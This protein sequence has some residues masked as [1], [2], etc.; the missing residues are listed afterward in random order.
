[1]ALVGNNKGSAFILGIFM[2]LGLA[3]LGDQI[4]TGFIRFKEFE[5]VVSVKGLSE[6]EVNADIVIWPITFTAASNDL[7]ELY[8]QLSANN[9]RIQQ[10][11]IGK[12]L[13][14]SEISRLAPA[15][16]DKSAQQYGGGPTP[17][18]RYSAQQTLTVY[19]RDVEKVRGLMND[20]AELGEGGIA[21]VG[22]NYENQVD[23]T[24]SGLNE[25]KPAMIEEATRN[26]RA[27]AE[28]F[29]QDSQSELGKIKRASQGQFTVEAR[30]RNN[31]HIMKV[32]VV[33]TVE[34]Y[35]SD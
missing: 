27:V 32:R 22:A 17:E 9:T 18:F 16:T 8:R 20:L 13:S 29:A 6:R 10:F 21:F 34:Y 26:A 28:K 19:S 31:P 4:A 1:M 7:G 33:S 30:D 15:V 24:F 3:A 14:E 2:F 23:Y 5:R 11:L 12:G 25:L 35:L